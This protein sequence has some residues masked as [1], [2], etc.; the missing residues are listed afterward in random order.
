MIASVQVILYVGSQPAAR[1][2]YRGL[3]QAEPGL[4]VP[5]MT[6]FALPGCR[7]GLMPEA[8]I[9]RLL[10]ALPEPVSGVPRCELYLVVDS[11][12]EWLARA[13]SLGATQ[14]AGVGARDWGHRVGYASDPD[15]H[16]LAFAR[17]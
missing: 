10:P 4:D 2:F 6:E 11:P 12:E 15:G 8:G 9:K 16:V 13:V 7:L 3:L 5:G 1:D 17:E 14:L